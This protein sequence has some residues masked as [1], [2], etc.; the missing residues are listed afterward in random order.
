MANFL[1]API[2]NVSKTAK[3][4]ITQTY[5]LDFNE[6]RMTARKIDG[7]EAINQYIR[8]ALMTPR[9]K[10][11]IYSS[12]Y[13]SGIKQLMT[14]SPS[15][16]YVEASIEH[17]VEDAIIHNPQIL[18]ISNFEYETEDDNMIISF[19]VMTIYGDLQ[20]KEVYTGV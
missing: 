20:V 19:K 8:K 11:L 5:A 2:Q 16:K 17:I 18:S 3:P 14:N 12:S 6:H 9:Y 7:I 10:C 15:K 4:K 1:T 13:G